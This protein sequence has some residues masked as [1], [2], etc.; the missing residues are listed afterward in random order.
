MQKPIREKKTSEV[1]ISTQCR[2]DDSHISTVFSRAQTLAILFVG[3][4]FI[5][6]ERHQPHKEEFM[7]LFNEKLS[8]NPNWVRRCKLLDITMK[9]LQDTLKGMWRKLKNRRDFKSFE[10]AVSSGKT[11]YIVYLS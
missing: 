1:E 10:K 5:R 3:E 11:F 7:S 8:E 4:M 2:D 9:D 6:N